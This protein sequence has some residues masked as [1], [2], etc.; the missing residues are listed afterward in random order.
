MHYFY[1]MKPERKDTLRQHI[2]ILGIYAILIWVFLF[3]TRTFFSG[4]HLSDDQILIS[5]NTRIEQQSFFSAAWYEIKDDL[6]LRFRPL[7]IFYYL[8]LAKWPYPDFTLISMVVSLQAIFTCYFFYR[9]ARYLKCNTALSFLF[10]L[11]ILCGNQGVVLWRNCV[12]ETFAIF[13]L[14]I[15]FFYLGRLLNRKNNSRGDT[16]AF[17]FFLLLSTLTKESFIILVPAVLFLK[18][19]QESLDT[20]RGFLFSVKQNSRLIVFFTLIIIAEIAIIYYYK[21]HSNRFIDYVGVDETTFN[22][23]NLLISMLR[24]WIT[25]GYLAIILPAV[26]FIFFSIKK[27]NKDVTAFF[28][29]LAVL[30]LLITLPQILLYSKSLI[31]ER[32]LLPGTIGSALVILFLQEYII[33]HPSTLNL[34]K[35]LFLPACTLLLC[36][37]TLL[38]T[39]GAIAYA[40]TGYEVKQMLATVIRHTKPADTILIVVNARGQSDQAFS[41]QNYL[42]AAIGGFRKAVYIEPFIDSTHK[43]GTVD[44][45]TEEN[46]VAG[47]KGINYQDIANPKNIKSIIFFSNTFMRFSL[48]HPDFDA[49]V[50]SKYNNGQFIIF[51]KK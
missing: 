50:F 30:F 37:Q 20:R 33:R 42:G 5:F 46:F 3:T 10:P 7:A 11:F 44:R 15:S 26:L 31:F 35:K 48:R 13:L 14:S 21:N 32:Y 43:P 24:L 27:Y 39:K 18:I 47:T 22:I 34:L 8:L 49:S 23:S 2:V 9:F 4:F 19:W 16:F 40:N 45:T 28:L 36:L 1:F 12:N 29:P 25:K 17:G 51:I 38:M 6:Y 41:T